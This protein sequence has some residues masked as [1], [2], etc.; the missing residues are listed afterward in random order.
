MHFALALT[1]SKL[2]LSEE[3][4]LE[5]VRQGHGV[6]HSQ[7]RHSMASTKIYKCIFFTF[8]IFNLTPHVN[9]YNITYRH[10][11]SYTHARTHARTHKHTHTQKGQ[12]HGYR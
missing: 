3:F 7:W 12:G 8:L 11:M 9:D 2:L 6:K 5:K 1:V 4:D 10:T